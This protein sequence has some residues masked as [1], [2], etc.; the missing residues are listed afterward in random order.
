MRSTSTERGSTTPQSPPRQGAGCVPR[1]EPDQANSH[2]RAL[3]P[4]GSRIAVSYSIL[5]F[6]DPRFSSERMP[7]ES[8]VW[9]ILKR[10]PLCSSCVPASPWLPALQ[11]QSARAGRGQQLQQ[12]DFVL[13]HAEGSTPVQTS[14]I[15]SSATQCTI[16]SGSPI[17]QGTSVRLYR[18]TGRCSGGTPVGLGEPTDK[19]QLKTPNGTVSA[20]HRWRTTP[21]PARRNTLW[22]LSRHCSV[23]QPA[24]EKRRRY[25]GLDGGQK[26]HGPIYSMSATLCT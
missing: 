15:E 9:D 1:P 21:R 13:R 17:R 6:Q 14:V 5:N 8:Y 4:D 24:H 22:E 7:I 3:A 2:V 26:H 11:P 25:C 12:P 10:T 16:S 23:D 18:Q 20:A 19:L